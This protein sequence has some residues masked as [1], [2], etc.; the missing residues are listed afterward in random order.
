LQDYVRRADASDA[1]AAVVQLQRQ[2]DLGTVAW[3]RLDASGTQENLIQQ[4]LRGPPTAI[5]K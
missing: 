2:Y 1:D 5:I 4:A 3:R